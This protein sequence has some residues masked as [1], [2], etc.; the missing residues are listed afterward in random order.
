VAYYLL[1]ICYAFEL[2]QQEVYLILSGLVEKSSNLFAELQQYFAHIHFAQR[3]E[4]SLPQTSHPHHYFT[5][6][7]NLAACVL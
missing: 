1:K 4:I 3:P 6:L 2:S 5:S 7:Y